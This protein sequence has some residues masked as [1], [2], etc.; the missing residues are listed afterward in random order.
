MAIVRVYDK[1]LTAAEINGNIDG[2][3]AVDPAD[4][5]PTTWARVKRGYE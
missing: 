3:F 5:L 2:A 1:A 4:K